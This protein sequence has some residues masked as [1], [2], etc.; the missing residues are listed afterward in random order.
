MYELFWFDF[1]MHH[2]PF[3]NSYIYVYNKHHLTS[4]S[5]LNINWISGLALVKLKCLWLIHLEGLNFED[6]VQFG[7][8]MSS[9]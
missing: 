4:I 9:N 5:N 7:M 1:A 8:W 3:A 6:K 2:S